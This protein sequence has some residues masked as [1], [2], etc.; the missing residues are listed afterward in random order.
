MKKEYMTPEL[1]TYS[2]R[3]DEQIAATCMWENDGYDPTAPGGASH[4]G[5]VTTPADR[6]LMPPGHHAR[7][8]FYSQ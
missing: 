4:A 5:I 1:E 2:V 6:E 8:A 3:P 7:A